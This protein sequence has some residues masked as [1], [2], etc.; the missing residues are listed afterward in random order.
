M[1][2]PPQVL[3]SCQIQT[4]LTGIR[5]RQALPLAEMSVAFHHP[6]YHTL[7]CPQYLF[8]AFNSVPRLVRRSE[9]QGDYPVNA[10]ECVLS[11]TR[12]M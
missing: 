4:T 1:N 5:L 12:S 9:T 3:V 2:N 11:T 8:R 7:V 10:L 6:P